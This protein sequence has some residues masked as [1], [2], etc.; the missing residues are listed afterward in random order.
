MRILAG[1][2]KG[3]SIATSRKLSYRPT[4]TRIRKSIFDRIAPYQY[5]SVLDLFAG[6]GIMGFEA[7]SRGAK[8][9]TLVENNKKSLTLL[10]ENSQKFQ[11]VDFQC[12]H[13]D[14]IKYL[15]REN[16]FDLIFADPPYGCY[17]TDG[18]VKT[19]LDRLSNQGKFV[20]ECPA[21]Q[22]PYP[23]TVNVIFGYTRIM[24][25]TKE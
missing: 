3:Q 16:A 10:K 19:I 8:S 9:V 25:W 20:L 13:C 15:K 14:A 24:I 18:L 7:S 21:S 6:S 4:Q 17:N 12:I 2:F 11:G 22:Q 23:D 5:D 1:R